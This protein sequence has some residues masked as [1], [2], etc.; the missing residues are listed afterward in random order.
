MDDALIVGGS[1]DAGPGNDLVR[2]LLQIMT[3]VQ[4]PWDGNSHTQLSKVLTGVM[5]NDELMFHNNERLWV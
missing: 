1:A 2:E 4:L 5:H 3:D